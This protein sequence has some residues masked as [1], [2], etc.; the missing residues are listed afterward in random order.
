MFTDTVFHKHKLSFPL[1]RPHYHHQH[2]LRSSPTCSLWLPL[3]SPP[4]LLFHSKY[5]TGQG[6]SGI[7]LLLKWMTICILTSVSSRSDAGW[8]SCVQS[9]PESHNYKVASPNHTC[10]SNYLQHINWLTPESQ[11]RGWKEHFTAGGQYSILFVA[12]FQLLSWRT[13]KASEE[14]TFLKRIKW[15]FVDK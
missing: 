15:M 1:M 7:S 4:P 9:G 5:G 14:K 11:T 12:G 3:F 2:P 6:A 10:W 8:M 13:R